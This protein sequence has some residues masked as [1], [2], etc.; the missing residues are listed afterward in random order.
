MQISYY[1][2]MRGEGVIAGGW[3]WDGDL[4]QMGG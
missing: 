3:C 2:R 1:S 4:F